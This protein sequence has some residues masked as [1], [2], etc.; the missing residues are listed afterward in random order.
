VAVAACTAGRSGEPGGKTEAGAAAG[1]NIFRL[2]PEASDVRPWTLTDRRLSYDASTLS[3]YI[4]GAAETYLDYGFNRVA[5]QEYSSGGESVVCSVYEMRDAEAAFGIFSSL[6]SPRKRRLEVGDDGFRADA[7]LAFWQARYYVTVETYTPR[8]AADRALE[9]FA[10]AVSGRI[11][12]RS[13]PPPILSRLPPRDLRP[14]TDRLLK[15]RSA[16]NAIAALGGAPGASLVDAGATVLA[17]DY[18]TAGGSYRLLVVLAASADAVDQVRGLPGRLF[19]PSAGYVPAA[20]HRVA[21]TNLWMRQGRAFA[22]QPIDGG[23]RLVVD[24]TRLEAAR[25]ALANDAQKR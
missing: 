14:S 10:R 21:D 22:S 6:R 15:G 23:V 11:G 19:T 24:A 18:E 4:D 7:Q 20:A 3:D 9:T 13:G 16:A 1:P 2:L 17:G 25:A 8:G 12:V 5:S